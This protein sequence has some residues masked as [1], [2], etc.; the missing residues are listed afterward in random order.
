M[1]VYKLK[2]E[3]TKSASSLKAAK[4]RKE[5]MHQ[6]QVAAERA[7]DALKVE[8]ARVEAGKAKLIEKKVEVEKKEKAL[9]A[10]VEKCHSFLLRICEECFWQGVWKATFYYNI[11]AEEPLY[12]LDKDVINGKLVPI[13]GEVYSTMEE[14]KEREN[15]VNNQTELKPSFEDIIEPL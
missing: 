15:V 7:Q 11:P 4:A 6:D 12:D 1:V 2:T 8:V 13:G 5:K 14:T 9:S 3:L 10:E